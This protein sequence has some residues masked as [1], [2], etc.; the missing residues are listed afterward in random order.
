[1]EVRFESENDIDNVWR[2]NSQAFPT[3]AEADLVNTLRSEADCIS[4]VAE[5]NGQIV[6]HILFS[7]VH[8]GVTT[9]LS[10]VGLAPMA[11][12]PEMQNNGIGSKLIHRGIS[13]CQSKD[14]DAIVVLGH[15]NYY[16]KFGFQ[17]SVKFG[18]KSEYDVPDDVFMIQELSSKSLESIN[19]TIRYHDAFKNV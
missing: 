1:M 6:G 15:P 4:L 18:I 2:L 16:P 19:G 7:P 9:N 17:P 13:E 8:I 3:I 11:V 10:L 5:V 12:V 14:V